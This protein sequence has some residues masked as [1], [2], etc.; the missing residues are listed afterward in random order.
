MLLKADI[1][2]NQ[3]KKLKNL[4]V[5]FSEVDL[6]DLNSIN[7]KIRFDRNNKTYQMLIG[8][9]YLATEGLLQTQKSGETKLME[10]LD[11]L[12]MSKLYEKFILNYYKKEHPEIKTSSSQIKW[13]LDDDYDFMKDSKKSK[14]TPEFLNSNMDYR[15]QNSN[16]PFFLLFN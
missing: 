9:C 13:Q 10:F 5:Y 14:K 3:K 16:N 4:I 15:I 11:N 1:P 7:W 2:L 8:I 6:L 12:R